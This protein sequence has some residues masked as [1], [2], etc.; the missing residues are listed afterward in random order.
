MPNP[1]PIPIRALLEMPAFL[2][3]VYPTVP[4]PLL[5]APSTRDKMPLLEQLWHVRD[6]ESDLY[7][8]RIR[9]TLAED[10][11]FLEPMEVGHW[12][13]ERGYL[14]R[15]VQPALAEFGA[16]RRALV[17]LLM[18]CTPEQLAREAL[19]VDNRVCNVVD[20][21]TELLDHDRD[22]RVRIAAVLAGFHAAPAA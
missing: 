15:E 9:R 22:H 12:P 10:R 1:S 6:C 13:E 18:G 2:E 7:A 14:A 11:P 8:P 19:R 4:D 20:L 16:M 3:A 21:V 5:R 17:A